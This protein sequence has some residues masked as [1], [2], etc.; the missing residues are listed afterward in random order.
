MKKIFGVI[1]ITVCMLICIIPS[2][3]MLFFPTTETTEN[4]PMAQTPTLTTQ[5]GKINK[6]FFEDF[7]DYFTEHMA[8]RN[9]MVYADAKIQTSLFR[10]SNVSGVI[11]GTNGW[12]YYSST[13]SDFLGT[14]LM[15]ER[16]L[17]NLAH[18]FSV[19]QDWTDS[20]GI[21]LILTFA[22]NKN[23]LYG[24]NMPYYKSYIV[25]TDHNAQL[26]VPYL[27]AFNVNYLNLF[28]LFTSQDET[29]YLLRDS[30][31]N[32]K[33]ANLVYNSLMDALELPHESYTD[34]SLQ[35]VKNENGD[36][37]KM[38][39][40]FWGELEEN[41]VYNIT[42]E[43]SYLSG[44]DVEDGWIAT[45]NENGT[46]ILLM[47]RDSFANTLIPFLSNEFQ[48]AYYSKGEPNAF[49]RYAEMYEPNAIIIE[50]AERNIKNYLNNPPILTPTETFLPTKQI[51][52]TTDT[53]LQV[54]E[55]I[56]D[57]NY[58]KFSGT[59]DEENLQYN[60]EIV[61]CVNQKAYKA[62]QTEENGYCLY[63][64][65]SEINGTSCNVQIYSVTDDNCVQTLNTTLDLPQ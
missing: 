52:A 42:Q 56:N 36:L 4:K 40:S 12:A 15:S 33:G 59:V 9:Q 18:N 34:S 13:L 65:K 62:Y 3:G 30:H 39:Y 8:L 17:Y 26:L 6:S 43:Y 41:Y 27:N 28:E 53:S 5:D 54:E 57:V 46:G 24:E 20:R 14:D 60:S 1:F 32:M 38:L 2:V 49:E 19:I 44:S 10:E 58:Y 64:K 47:F 11:S 55:C 37:N 31:W 50:K 51:Y 16:E 22:P 23:T 25:N 61:V 35:L 29:L 45:E 21:D 7:E 63:L 48:N